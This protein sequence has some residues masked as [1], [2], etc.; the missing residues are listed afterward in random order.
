MPT[1]AVLG[2][3]V[4]GLSAAHELV[5]RGFDVTV[6][7]AA[8]GPGGKARSIFVP[9]TGTDGRRDLPGEHGF[10]FFPSFYRHLPDTMK[11]IPFGRNPRGVFDNLTATSRTRLARVDAPAVDVITRFP[12]S[13]DDLTQLVRTLVIHDLGLPWVDVAYVSALFLMLLTTCPE[14]RMAE[15]ENA[16]W[17][18][19]VGADRRSP[20]FRKF[21]ADIAVRSLVAMCPRRA[22][23]R[24]IGTVGMQLW[25]DHARPGAEVDQ[26]LD[27]PTGD[28][29]LDPWVAHLRRRGVKLRW[30]ARVAGI[31]CVDARVSHVSITTTEG[32]ERVEADHYIAAL[33]VERMRLLVTEQ[34][35]VIDPRFA[36]LDELA[37]EWMTG[38]QFFLDIPLP[39][40]PGHVV[41]VDAP[42]AVT[43]ISQAQFWP[44]THLGR[45]GNGRVRGVLS[46]IIAN[47]EVPGTHVK[48]PAVAC[49]ADEIREELW[50][51]LKA[52]LGR[53]GGPRLTDRNLID[54]YLADSIELGPD[55]ARNREPLFINTAGSWRHRPE[56]VTRIENLFLA[57][58]YVRTNTDI[59]TMEGA[60]EAARR[61]TNAILD[62]SGVNMPPCRIWQL[63][64]PLPFRALQQVD[65]RRFEGGDPHVLAPVL[66]ARG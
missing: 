33:P 39:I 5:E 65:R 50:W 51:Q 53:A 54:W 63:Q 10:R 12:A 20:A 60:N 23:T 28:V 24:T 43:A 3:G 21:F 41:L 14:R 9:G 55:G 59:A 18:D 46:T 64:E 6:Y 15:H 2:G 42:W 61:A 11:R 27:G 66:A 19:F 62:A 45:F 4:A 56:P 7:E 47:W 44:R 22:N 52:H 34:M 35:K 31:S 38:V 16:R 58:D 57:A 17:W 49:S 13:L 36:D 30:G 8:L 25:I 48:K 37:T 26:L 32:P 40:V 1:V 29:W